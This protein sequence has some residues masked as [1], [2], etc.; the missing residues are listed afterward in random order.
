LNAN[1][2][3]IGRSLVG[4]LAAF[5]GCLAP[6]LLIPAAEGAEPQSPWR[7]ITISPN[8]AEIICALNVCDR[9]VG[10]DKFCVHPP[11][12]AERPRVG[13]LF[14]PDIER[15]I[16]LRPDLV[17]LRG[18]NESLE[19]LCERQGIDLFL[20]RTERLA[21]IENCV[22]ELGRKL[23]RGEE[24]QEIVRRFRERL[25]TLRRRSAGRPRP[26]VLMTISR[27]PDA[28]AN[29][30]TAAKGSFLDDMLELAGGINAFGHM[31]M[32]YPPISPEAI[33][34]Q[35]P[36]VI[37][38]FMPELS[39]AEAARR[40]WAEAWSSLGMVP[41]AATG[42]IHVVTDANALVPS[43]RV[44]DVAEKICTILHETIQTES[45]APATSGGGRSP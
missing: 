9:L 41:A 21:D 33:V 32:A 25:E 2:K 23:N 13:G 26:R 19:R 12:L 1:R 10:V 39:A 35:R 29:V 8:A 20:D 15:I 6:S 42:R 36:D 18:R 27:R 28:I 37:I 3:T 4:A 45:P 22:L 38:E 30:M 31:D 24:A 5:V 34:A 17:V 11:E 44:L 43:P 16:S 7:I 14:D 40:Q